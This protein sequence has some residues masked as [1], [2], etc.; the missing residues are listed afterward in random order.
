MNIGQIEN[1]ALKIIDSVNNNQPSEDARVELKS[2]WTADKYKAARQIAGHANAARS[3]YI[4]WLIGV[5]ERNGVT[6]VE[7]EEFSNWYSSVKSFFDANPP[8]VTNVNI[9]IEEKTVVA[10]LFDTSRTPYVIKNPNHGSPNS[11]PIE[12]EVPWREGNSTRS[13]NHTNL[14]KL[15]IPLTVLPDIEI[16]NSN[17]S[18]Y[19]EDGEDLWKINIQTFI[20]PEI[21]TQI[22]LP[23]HRATGTI[24]IADIIENR[25]FDKIRFSSPDWRGGFPDYQKPQDPLITT[26]PSSAII[27]GPGKLEIN[28][29]LTTSKLNFSTPII[30]IVRVK[31]YPARASSAIPLDLSI[32][33]FDI[34]KRDEHG[35][36]ELYQRL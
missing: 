11:G 14:I 23:E 2:I 3:D 17:L 29:S 36:W 32:D 5:N 10:L 18:L 31:I 21:S 25:P 30:A 1:W 12:F 34:Y 26:N 24:S 15:L 7:H 4:L 22:V 35:S 16:L 19:P 8:S 13:A 28:A 27:N 6:G 33:K 20:T 9:F